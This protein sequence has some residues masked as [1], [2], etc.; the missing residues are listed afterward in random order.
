MPAKDDGSMAQ[1][2]SLAAE[3]HA[4]DHISERGG[5]IRRVCLT[6]VSRS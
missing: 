1:M 5:L 3:T 6:R 2:P 4:I